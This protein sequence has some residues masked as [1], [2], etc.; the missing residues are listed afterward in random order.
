[1]HFLLIYLMLGLLIAVT[2]LLREGS[3]LEQTGSWITALLR[4]SVVT[5]AWLPMLMVCWFFY[6]ISPAMTE[7]EVKGKKEVKS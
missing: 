3:R 4:L 6:I 1:M 7:N 2:L 5:A